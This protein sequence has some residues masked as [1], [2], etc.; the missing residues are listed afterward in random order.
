M[1]L[2][3]INFLHRMV[4]EIQ[5]GQTFSCS[6]TTH[7]VIRT[8]WVRKIPTALKALRSINRYLSPIIIILQI[9]QA[10]I[11]L[12]DMLCGSGAL[13]LV[14]FIGNIIFRLSQ[15]LLKNSQDLDKLGTIAMYKNTP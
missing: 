8:P 5:T 11:M 13:F 7:P 14:L 9:F 15:N 1:S 3:S 2:P 4:S 6:L 10:L 12:S